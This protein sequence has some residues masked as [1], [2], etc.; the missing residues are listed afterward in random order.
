MKRGSDG[1]LIFDAAFTSTV[2]PVTFATAATSQPHSSMQ[3]RYNTLAINAKRILSNKR[4]LAVEPM[5]SARS[6]RWIRYL[7][8]R[9]RWLG[10]AK[11]AC[12]FEEVEAAQ[13]ESPDRCSSDK[14][15]WIQ[16]CRL[17]ANLFKACDAAVVGLN[18][19]PDELGAYVRLGLAAGRLWSAVVQ[20]YEGWSV[21]IRSHIQILQSLATTLPDPA[22]SDILG[23]LNWLPDAI[24]NVHQETVVETVWSISTR[25]RDSVP[26][27]TAP[28]P[29]KL[30]M[31]GVTMLD[32]ALIMT[33]EDY[34][35]AGKV[36]DRWQ[37]GSAATALESIGFSPEH[38]QKKLFKPT[39]LADFVEGEEGEETCVEHDLRN[40]LM[41][42][43]RPPRPN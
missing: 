21:D 14:E 4:V 33:E 39:V 1:V 40:R 41:G 5:S 36:V 25:L 19:L 23:V 18:S 28:A 12:L 13:N 8:R 29:G 3:A 38:K 2:L 37:K 17:T 6:K 31:K 11:H 30:V 24:R 34:K 15:Q 32:A 7:T 26:T 16:S 20:G 42:K 35:L 43:A 27:L 22:R 9:S 10:S